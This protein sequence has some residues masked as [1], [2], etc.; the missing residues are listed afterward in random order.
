MDPGET[1]TVEVQVTSRE[2]EPRSYSIGIE[3][4][5][6][7]DDGTDNIQFYGNGTGP[8]SARSWITPAVVD[9]RLKHGERAFIPVT[10]SIPKDASVGDH[11]SVV[12][13]QRDPKLGE[14]LK[15]GFNLVARIG[16]LLLIT[17]KGDIVK[18]GS[19]ESFTVSRS[20]YWSIPA[21]FAIVYKNTGTVHLT[22]S[23]HIEIANIFGIPVD[24]IGVKDWYVL[25]NSV[26]RRDIQWQPKFALGYYTATLHLTS[27]GQSD[28]TIQTQTFW[29]IPALPVLLALLAIF[30]VSFLVQAFFSRFEIKKRGENAKK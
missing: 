27:A 14:E 3:D 18:Q 25:R 11:Y 21:R 5:A 1:R 10:I 2:G 13:F 12:L 19:M 28:E 20:L 16:A 30:F 17:V 9:F 7:T 6:V 8:F 4:F 24:D 22:P 15:G 23:G 29:I 26:R